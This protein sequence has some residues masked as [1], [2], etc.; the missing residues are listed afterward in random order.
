ME[1]RMTIKFSDI[2]GGGIPYGDNAGRP[3]NP[4]IGKLYSNGESQRLELYTASGW[5]NIVQEVPGVSGVI[6][7]YLETNSSNT[8]QITGTNFA[9]GAIAYAIGTDGVEVPATTTT[10]NSLL[11]LTA[12]FSGLVGANEPY[13]IKVVN[14]SNLFGLLPDA[15]FVNQTPIWQT[16]SGSLGTF[17][18]QV[19][20]SVSATASDPESQT[21]TY[22]IVSGALPGGTSLNTS[23]GL[24]SGTLPNIASD[25]TYS[26]SIRASDGYNTST[27]SFSISVTYDIE[28]ELL[29][30]AGGGSGGG[31]VGGGGGAGELLY[32][33][34]YKV[35]PGSQALVTVGAG[36]ASIGTTRVPGNYGANSVFGTLIARG[37]GGGGAHE[38]G[39]RP[40]SGNDGLIGHAGRPGGSA[41][42]GGGG[43]DGS[44]GVGGIS[45]KYIYA[46][47]EE[48]GNNGGIGRAG[49]WAGGGGGGAGSAGSDSPSASTGG[50]GG[51]G[52]QYSITGTA[53][54]YAA[55]G[56]GCYNNSGGSTGRASG[57][58]GAGN[59]DNNDGN[60][61]AIAN[62]GSGGGGI[63]DMGDA[64]AGSSGVVIVA[65]PNTHPEMT[66][67]GTLTYDTPTRSGYRVYRF[68]AGSGT[69]TF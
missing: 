56:G 46:D 33:S 34:S 68:T 36:G 64:G 19:S 14:P 13:D 58:G 51:N 59:G 43:N 37:G 32:S 15:L 18:E 10:Y 50:P 40:P 26:F 24:I 65:Y 42:G 69:I 11:S 22:A 9:T 63:R 3:A 47:V 53:Q 35:V 27:R 49:S 12:T 39:L 6:G 29:V 20:V 30:V 48:Y 16:P 5:N 8:I 55:G 62:T 28:M 2:T 31:Q 41:G 60:R 67:P 66:I 54:F 57:I 25:T 7:Q 45:N 4:G 1:T 52:L 38:D 61:N 21:I 17:R 23:T 44:N